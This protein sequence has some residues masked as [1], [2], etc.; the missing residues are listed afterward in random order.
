MNRSI[1]H[2]G[3]T[4]SGAISHV[5]A[6]SALLLHT[7]PVTRITASCDLACYPLLVDLFPLSLNGMVET[8]LP[9][10]FRV[11]T[12]VT[13]YQGETIG[14][15][16]RHLLLSTDAQLQAG[17]RLSLRVRVPMEISGSPFSEIHFSGRVLA[18]A[19]LAGGNFG[20]HLEIDRTTPDS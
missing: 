7:R 11:A 8:K 17:L 13:E 4:Q 6:A 16:P 20:Y 3:C 15:S 18:G 19:E 10:R 14:I 12:G 2:E 5:P 1:R 9:V